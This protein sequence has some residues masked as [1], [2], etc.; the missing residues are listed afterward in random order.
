MREPYVFTGKMMRGRPHGIIAAAI[1]T[2]PAASHARLEA[3]ALRRP[4]AWYD[5]LQR[6]HYNVLHT[7]AICPQQTCSHLGFEMTKG[8]ISLSHTDVPSIKSG[9]AAIQ[10]QSQL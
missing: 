5:V 10:F 3:E 4:N 9:I 1:K 8:A 7:N 6:H 2:D